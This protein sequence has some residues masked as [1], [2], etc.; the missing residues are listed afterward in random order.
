MR[1]CGQTFTPSLLREIQHFINTESSLSRRRLSRHIC[2][3]LNWRSCNGK[4]QEGSCRKAVV[5]L[6]RDGFLQLP[7][8]QESFS[9]SNS[10]LPDIDIEI[11]EV[12]CTLEELG[13]LEIIEITNRKS[14]NAKAWKSLMNR[15]HYLGSGKPCGGQIRYLVKSEQYG[16]LG[17]LSFNSGLYALGKRDEFIGWSESARIAN[18]GY[19]VLNSRFLILPSVHV[20]NL[21]SHILKLALQRLP[22][23]WNN[24]YGITPVLVETFVDPTRFDGACYKAANFIWVG[25]T[26]GR[27]DG[28]KKDIFLYP[29]NKQWQSLLCK[30][31]AVKLFEF[32][33][34]ESPQNWMQQEFATCRLHDQRLKERLY[35]IADDFFNM[36]LAN[37]PEASGS[38]AA[39]KGSYRFF[40]NKKVTMDV[41]LTPHTESTIRRIR[42]H[43]VVLAP[44][45]TTTLQYSHP[46]TKGLGPVNNNRDSTVGM[47]L[48]DTLAFTPDGTPLGVLDAQCWTR[49]PEDRNKSAR[50]DH[51]PIEQKESNKWLR[52]YKKVAEVQA[53]CPDTML[54]SMGDRESDMYELLIET[55]K[56]PNGPK[57]LIRSDRN[58]FRRVAGDDPVSGPDDVNYL[59]DYMSKQPLAGELHV[60]IPKR[61]E[62]TARTAVVEIRYGQVKILPPKN[63]AQKGSVKLWAVYIL[64]SGNK[65]PDTQIEWLLLTTVAVESFKDAKEKVEWYS[66]RWGIEVYHRTLKSGC[67]ILDRQLG[68]AENLQACLGVDMVV[69]WRIYHLTMLGR[70]IPDHPCTVFFEDVEWKALYCHAQKTPIAPE[71]PP[72]LK[73]AI[74]MVGKLGGYLGR[75]SD[76]MP[77][78][79][80]IWRGLQKLDMGVDMYMIFTNSSSPQIRKSYTEAMLG[81]HYS[82]P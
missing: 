81:P 27:R 51:V 18:L 58:R 43:R 36:P 62:I 60:H 17:A 29:F 35:R 66:G 68:S 71:H 32:A 65:D 34:I 33:P 12:I 14:Y 5:R 3:L 15:F 76:G 70:E 46:T 23:D 20:K 55:Q 26:A 19:I 59:W 30:E 80:C 79:E 13:P 47:L 8:L 57:L 41:I 77:G 63:L 50:R 10:A 53:Q 39:C 82:G 9:F 4:L 21:A 31:P 49:D 56:N 6:E 61:E 16:Y 69:A 75:K 28:I 73:E 67:R 22:F 38:I 24:R 54:V 72:T 1:V 74:I 11:P 2:E 48:H 25:T 40:S 52:S 64:E 42:E 44:Q 78:T 7:A 37:I 45:D